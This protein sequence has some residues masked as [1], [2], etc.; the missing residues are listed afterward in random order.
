M[1]NSR[2]GKRRDSGDGSLYPRRNRAG[3]IIGWVGAY[4]VE[5]ESGTKRK[6]VYAKTRD[7]AK[8]LLAKTIAD[9]NEGATHTGSLESDLEVSEYLTSWLSDCEG[10]LKVTSY[11]RYEHSVQRHLSPAIGDVG[12][13]KLSPAHIQA[14]YQAK[15]RD[16]LAPRTV[17]HLHEALRRALNR[18]VKLG[19]IAHNPCDGVEPPK[20]PKSPMQ[21]LNREQSRRFVESVGATKWEAIFV[22]AITTGMRQGEMLGLRWSDTDLEIRPRASKPFFRIHFRQGARNYLCRAQV[23]GIPPRGSPHPC[24]R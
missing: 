13:S 1:A 5:E 24:C 23:V 15:L 4:G 17:I 7:D 3:K 6:T 22:L 16:G 8:A 10:A 20:A 18:A 19:L 11:R 21:P 12:L 14:L 9:R 2:G